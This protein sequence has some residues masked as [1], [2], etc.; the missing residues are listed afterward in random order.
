[1]RSRNPALFFAQSRGKCMTPRQA[2]LG[3]EAF[4]DETLRRSAE[5]KYHPTTFIGMRGR[6]GTLTAISRLV[7]NGDIQSG[8]KR[9]CQLGLKEWTIESAVLKFPEEFSTDVQECAA[10]RL[11]QAGRK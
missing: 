9:L 7:V 8:F 3:L 11:K 5:H 6:H 2:S 10:F 4:V 1:M